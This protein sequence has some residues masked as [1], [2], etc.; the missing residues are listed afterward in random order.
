ML[1][2]YT[3]DEVL[4]EI[5]PEDREKMLATFEVSPDVPSYLRSI[6]KVKEL[7]VAGCWLGNKLIQ[8]GCSKEQRNSIEFAHGQRCLAG[9]PYEEAAMAWNKYVAGQPDVGGPALAAEILKETF[10][11]S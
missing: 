2:T 7:W 4:S 6:P 10:G 5:T 1:K 8:V 3:A 11:E 9:D